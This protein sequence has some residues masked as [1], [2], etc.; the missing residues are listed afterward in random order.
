MKCFQK[1]FMKR[2]NYEIM[3]DDIRNARSINDLS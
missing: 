3:K 2:N 1:L